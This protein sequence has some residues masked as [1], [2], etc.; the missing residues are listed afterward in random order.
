MARPRTVNPTGPTRRVSVIV[1][2]PV[3]RRLER[4]AKQQGI[5]VA[6]LVRRELDRVA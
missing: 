3:V 5:S 1:A 4:R 6:E 2:E